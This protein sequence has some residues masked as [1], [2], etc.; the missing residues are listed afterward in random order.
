MARG[1][2][3]GSQE[4]NHPQWNTQYSASRSWRYTIVQESCSYHIMGEV[5]VVQENVEDQYS[6]P[7]VP[8]FS[9]TPLLHVLRDK[10]LTPDVL[11]EVQYRVPFSRQDEPQLSCVPAALANSTA[12]EYIIFAAALLDALSPGSASSMRFANLHE[13]PDFLRHARQKF[14][15]D[16]RISYNLYFCISKE[17]RSLSERDPEN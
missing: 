1:V 3:I 2:R 15:Y 8:F 5:P 11:D 13:I 9:T 6:F 17:I 10:S 7:C 14:P 16:G 4:G 12:G